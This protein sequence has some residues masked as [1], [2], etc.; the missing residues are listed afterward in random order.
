MSTRNQ[1]QRLRDQLRAVQMTTIGMSQLLIYANE[2]IEELE[3]EIAE[4]RTW[5]N[6]EKEKPDIAFKAAD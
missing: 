3:K 6:R 1:E 5:S 2:R 4:M